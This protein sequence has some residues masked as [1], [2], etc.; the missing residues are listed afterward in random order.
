MAKQFRVNQLILSGTDATNVFY[1]RSNPSGYITTGQTGNFGGSS[2]YPNIYKFNVLVNFGFTGSGQYDTASVTLSG[3][4]GNF[5]TPSTTIICNP[6]G[7]T[8]TNHM[9]DDVWAEQIRA[10]PSNIVSGVSFDVV[11]YAPNGTFG[12]YQIGVICY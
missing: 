7:V 5:V 12:E 9:P 10:Y 8:T 1:P 4:S 6:M 3:I 11:A 2:S